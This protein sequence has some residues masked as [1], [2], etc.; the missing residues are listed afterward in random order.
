MGAV[1][2]GFDTR[3]NGATVRAFK[4]G[5]LDV[6]VGSIETVAEGLTLVQ[7]D[8]TIFVEKSFKPYRNEQAVMRIYRMG[9]QRPVTVRDYVTPNTVDR[10]KRKRIAT[11]SDRAE[12]M[13]TAAEF[14]ALM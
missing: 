8:M 9:Q 10:N 6:L 14:A 13:M 4:R 3:T 12:R 11:K 1:H 7:A 2:G 5:E